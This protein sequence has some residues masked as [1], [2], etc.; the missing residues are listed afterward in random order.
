MK[1]IKRFRSFKELKAYESGTETERVIRMKHLAF[2][3]LITFIRSLVIRKNGIAK[4]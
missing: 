4:S 1:T 2:E 3:K